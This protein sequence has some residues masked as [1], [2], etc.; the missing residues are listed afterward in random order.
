MAVQELALQDRRRPPV[1]KTQPASS[2][3]GGSSGHRGL[4]G[5]AVGPA[6]SQVRTLQGPH[7]DSVGHLYKDLGSDSAV[8]G[9][10]SQQGKSREYS[11][12]LH[13]AWTQ[14]LGP[15]E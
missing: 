13:E 5:G 3:V 4:G 2:G 6:P 8:T 15:Y 1:P 11:A 7:H 9:S 12:P 10:R 14:V